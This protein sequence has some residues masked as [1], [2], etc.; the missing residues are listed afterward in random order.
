MTYSFSI[1]GGKPRRLGADALQAKLSPDDSLLAYVPKGGGLWVS[2]ADGE[3]PRALIAGRPRHQFGPLD[4]SQIKS[5][6][7]D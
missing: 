5:L 6:Y 1:L 2:G 4:W 3:N 7:R